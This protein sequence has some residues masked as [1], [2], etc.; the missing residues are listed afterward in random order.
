M[1]WR[2]AVLW[3]LAGLALLVAG[4]AIAFHVL[5]DSERLIAL[6]QDKARATWQRELKAE[7]VSVKLWPVPSLHASK[8]TLANPSWAKQPSLLAVGYA[9]A[10]F[11]LLP[12]LT[13]RVRI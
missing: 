7:G 10:D 8:V 2:R 11:E 5:V 1:N 12:L 3:S 6:A 9:R 13:G 4:C